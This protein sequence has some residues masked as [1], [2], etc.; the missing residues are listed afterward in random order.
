MKKDDPRREWVGIPVPGRDRPGMAASVSGALYR[1]R[2]GI[3]RFSQ[4]V[5]RGPFAERLLGELNFQ[6]EVSY[7][8]S[9]VFPLALQAEHRSITDSGGDLHHKPLHLSI[10]LE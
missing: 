5:I 9:L 6:V 10:P 4:T 2:S 7:F 1:H 8:P 3:E